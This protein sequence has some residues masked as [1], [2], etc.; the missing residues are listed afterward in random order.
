MT[1]QAGKPER[2]ADDLA[3]VEAVMSLAPGSLT[4]VLR[5]RCK[6]HEPT[7]A[8][9]VPSL[10]HKDQEGERRDQSIWSQFQHT[11]TEWLPFDLMHSPKEGEA[12][13]ARQSGDTK[14]P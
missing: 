13:L 9:L 11:T 12:R 1:S 2:S 14:A 3:K 7:S 8:E 5:E 4:P 10:Q 6:E